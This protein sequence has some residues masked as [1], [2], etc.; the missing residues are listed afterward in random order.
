MNRRGQ[1]SPRRTII[2]DEVKEESPSASPSSAS[3][4]TKG[5]F[6]GNTRTIAQMVE[7]D[8]SYDEV[9][10]EDETTERTD[11]SMATSDTLHSRES[12]EAPQSVTDTTTSNTTTSSVE[13]E[14]SNLKSELNPSGLNPEIAEFDPT[15]LTVTSAGFDGSEEQGNVY[16]VQMAIQMQLFETLQALELQQRCIQHQIDWVLKPKYSELALSLAQLRSLPHTD[17]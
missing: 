12:T 13:V 1:I 15:S 3:T 11:E 16:S 14:Q 10:E 9:D 7:E 8:D 2:D 17:H 5:N 6:Q 4:T